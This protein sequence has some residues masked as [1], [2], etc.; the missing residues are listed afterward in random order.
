MPEA[1]GGV[2]VDHANR[3]HERVD[4]R[5]TDKIEPAFLQ[6]F[7]YYIGFFGSCGKFFK[8]TQTALERFMP[9]KFPDVTFER[10]K[11][12]LDFEERGRVADGRFDL[13]AVAHDAFVGKKLADFLR[14]VVDDPGGVEV[15]ERAAGMN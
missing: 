15:V 3:L 8:I 4:N 2:V 12:F 6:V 14:T 5:R 11:L 1:V 10:A 13:Q 9:D 7:A